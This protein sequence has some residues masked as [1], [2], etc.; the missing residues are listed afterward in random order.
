M[1]TC[2]LLAEDLQVHWDGAPHMHAN[3]GW[4][5]VY[6]VVTTLQAPECQV[7]LQI[8]LKNNI[9]GCGGRFDKVKGGR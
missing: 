5:P 1:A 2:E 7:N 6:T 8:C 3:R 9:T 4:E